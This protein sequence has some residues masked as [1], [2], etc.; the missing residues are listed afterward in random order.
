MNIKDLDLNL[1]KS[2]ESFENNY[3]ETLNNNELD[4]KTFELLYNLGADIKHGF[5]S[6][7]SEIVNYLKN[8]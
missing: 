6:F 5:D 3:K 8:N 2:I 1:L 4:S 7:Q